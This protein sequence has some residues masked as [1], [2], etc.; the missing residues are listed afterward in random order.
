MGIYYNV[1]TLYSWSWWSLQHH[2]C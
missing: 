1:L 2:L